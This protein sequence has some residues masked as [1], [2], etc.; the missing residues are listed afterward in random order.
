MSRAKI[1]TEVDAVSEIKKE[2]PNHSD[3]LLCVSRPKGI[4]KFTFYKEFFKFSSFS[5]LTIT[6]VIKK[7][8]VYL[9][10]T[11]TLFA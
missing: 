5:Y 3:F 9:V 2:L 4:K 10:R 1:T 6:K 8:L 11:K 7:S